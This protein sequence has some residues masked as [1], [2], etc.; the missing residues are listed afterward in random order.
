MELNGVSSEPG[1]I[2]DPKNTLWSAYRDLARHWKI[3]A[4]ISIQQQRRGIMPVP[5]GI[6]WKVVKGHFIS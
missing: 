3:I 1:H 2:Y 5:L 6:L 4:D